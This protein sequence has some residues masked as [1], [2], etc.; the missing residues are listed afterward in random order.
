MAKGR[1]PGPDARRSDQAVRLYRAGLTL[2]EAARR[3]GLSRH[4]LRRALR[5]RGVPRRAGA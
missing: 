2:E 1:G 3:T 5:Q 4:Q